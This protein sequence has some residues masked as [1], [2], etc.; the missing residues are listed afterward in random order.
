MLAL[1]LL[2][3]VRPSLS[4]LWLALPMLGLGY[5]VYVRAEP[6]TTFVNVAASLALGVLWARTFANGQLLRFG[7]LDLVL[8]Y[9]GAGFEAMLRPWPV[10]VDSGKQAASARGRGQLALPILRGLV[11]AAPILCVF[12]LL[13][14]SADLVFA[15]RFRDLLTAL[16]L[17]NI[18]ELIVRVAL[19]G[20]AAFVAIGLLVQALR[21]KPYS[22]VGEDGNL[23]PRVIGRVESSVVL[24]SL[25]L[26]F[27]AFVVVQFR[28]LFGGAQNIAEAG[29]SYSEYARRGFGELTLVVFF[30]LLLLLALSAVVRRE[31]REGTIAF[32]TLNLLLVGLV[33]V[34][35]VSALQ[36]LLLYE[37][38]Y[39]FT[40]LRTYAHAAII[41][42]G[43]LFVPY[44]VA[45]VAGRLRWFAPGVL[46]AVLGFV[47]TLNGLNVDSFIARQNLSRYDRG[48]ELHTRYLITLSDDAVPALVVQFARGDPIVNQVLGPGLA[49]RAEELNVDYGRGP[50][51]SDHQ[52]HGAAVSIL[53]S[54]PGLS[55]YAVQQGSDGP[56][57]Y[58]DGAPITCQ[59]LLQSYVLE[60][61]LTGEYRE[62]P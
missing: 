34:I 49:C 2:E 56:F 42:L 48:H 51:Q 20:L 29:Y 44:L 53:V 28:Y 43:L 11:L 26:L 25:N 31:T 39:G 5:M 18:P 60:P 47:G 8:S 23:F 1:A 10:L 7:L 9:V 12:T 35:V 50:W 21:P 16:N 22:L 6:L 40:R 14:T 13:L 38:I 46:L 32:N 33:G 52:S 45:L 30:A 19:I 27:A 55:N 61:G 15:D 24:G 17:D 57:V 36:R 3:R 54:L 41:W 58:L 59:R 4:S 62:S 37:E